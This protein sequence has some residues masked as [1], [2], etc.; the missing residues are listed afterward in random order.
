[1]QAFIAQLHL[2]A[3]THSVLVYNSS[4]LYL[5]YISHKIKALFTL[6]CRTYF[7]LA[8]STATLIFI[9]SFCF[10]FIHIYYHWHRRTMPLRY[11]EAHWSQVHLRWHLPSPVHDCGEICLNLQGSVLNGSY[12]STFCLT[13]WLTEPISLSRPWRRTDTHL[14]VRWG[15]MSLIDWQTVTEPPGHYKTISAQQGGNIMSAHECVSVCARQHF[16]C[17]SVYVWMCLWVWVV[18]PYT[19]Y[20]L[21]LECGDR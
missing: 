1:M 3:T 14:Q 20:P 16:F 12:W 4:D 5:D 7:C 10:C 21:H 15:G 11:S 19:D 17:T 6:L 9:P 18:K 13:L 2:N 8:R